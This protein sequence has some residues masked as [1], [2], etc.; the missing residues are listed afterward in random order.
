M[1]WALRRPGTGGKRRQPRVGPFR[2]RAEAEA[3][4]RSEILRTSLG[5]LPC[6]YKVTVAEYC[7]EWLVR[8]RPRLAKT[9]FE[10]YE[11]II[12]NLLVPA[13]GD[14]KLVKL[15]PPHLQALYR[16]LGSQSMA[17]ND[18]VLSV[19]ERLA[20]ARTH[21]GARKLKGTWQYPLSA[22]R[23]RKVHAVISSILTDARKRGLLVNNPAT[24]TGLPAVVKEPPLV[25]TQARVEAWRESGQKPAKVMVWTPEQCVAFLQYMVEVRERDFALYLLAMTRG[26][27]CGELL[28][29]RWPDVDLNE[30]GSFTT[31]GTKTP[32]SR[33][34]IHL[35][36]ANTVALGQWRHAQRRE[37]ERSG[38]LWTHS[39]L[40][41]TDPWGKRIS[42]H[43]LRERFIH[44]ADEA[45]L[46]PLRFHDLRH[47]AA[48]LA[49][50]SGADLKIIS[51][52]LG[53]SS[54]AF[55]ADFYTNVMPYD[56]RQAAEAIL[57][58]LGRTSA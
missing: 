21:H 35:G 7:Q 48:S 31:R 57:A 46:P 16:V 22:K 58:L 10:D 47:C 51:E 32:R 27:R 39:G 37:R 56:D 17:V 42:R 44:L 19:T 49:L 45:G 52:T 29:L 4:V 24:Y 55:T 2:T 38:L 41:F 15:L 14:L 18:L 20:P 12:D 40:V 26:P 6:A 34:T 33:R 50:A 25:W 13:W 11:R 43:T 28:R 53:H 9:S 8:N 36:Q 1:V 23:I 5:G 30:P 54:Y 3:A